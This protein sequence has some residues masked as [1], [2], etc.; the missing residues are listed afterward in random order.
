MSPKHATFTVG[1]TVLLLAGCAAGPRAEPEP[2]HPIPLDYGTSITASTATTQVRSLPATALFSSGP[3]DL[4]DKLRA[5]G[6]NNFS[7]FLL[8]G[9]RQSFEVLNSLTMDE[10]ER[11]D[12]V[13]SLWGG[14]QGDQTTLS[15]TT[16]RA[17]AKRQK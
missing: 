15:I 5:Y 14:L 9:T 4:R 1:A 7:V 13:K 16:R 11:V 12:L 8:D 10:I 6:M 17:A 2:G 3:F